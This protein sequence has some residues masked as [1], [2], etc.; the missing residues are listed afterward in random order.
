MASWSMRD[1]ERPGELRDPVILGAL[2]ELYQDRECDGYLGDM[3][4]ESVYRTREAA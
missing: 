3:I 4:R 1:E 2:T